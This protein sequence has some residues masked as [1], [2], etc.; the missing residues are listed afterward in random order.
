MVKEETIDYEIFVETVYVDENGRQLVLADEAEHMQ[1]RP[2]KKSKKKKK[3]GG[4][5]YKWAFFL[6]SMFTGLGFTAM[7]ENPLFLFIGLG[8]GFLWFADP[9]YDKLVG[10]AMDKSKWKQV[11]D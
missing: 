3:R 7:S 5:K 2:G 11:K 10:G 1:S 8:L 9:V 6:A 4:R